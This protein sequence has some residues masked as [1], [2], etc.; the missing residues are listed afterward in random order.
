MKKAVGVKT[1]LAASLGRPE[2]RST[3]IHWPATWTT[4]MLSRQ[5]AGS[6]DRITA[7]LLA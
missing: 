1:L 2:L 7:V 6:H 3:T 4:R 5:S